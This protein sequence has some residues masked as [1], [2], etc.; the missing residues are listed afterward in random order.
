MLYCVPAELFMGSKHGLA[1]WAGLT[2]EGHRGA[3]WIALHIRKLPE[4][5]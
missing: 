5:R 4:Q 1:S 3:L 2:P